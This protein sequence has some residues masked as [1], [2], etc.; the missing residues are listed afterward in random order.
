MTRLAIQV[1]KPGYPDQAIFDLLE[2][3]L[4]LIAEGK[5]DPQFAQAIFTWQL[6]ANLGYQP[7]LQPIKP[8]T[9][10]YFSLASGRISQKPGRNQETYHRLDSKAGKLL[11]AMLE[12]DLLYL[13]RL[14]KEKKVFSQAYQVIEGYAAYQL[15]IKA[16]IC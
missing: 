1:L 12:K 3:T 15:E 2:K 14:K 13:A 6:T 16:E 8:G 7:S 5:L 10:A 4:Q 11:K 9:A